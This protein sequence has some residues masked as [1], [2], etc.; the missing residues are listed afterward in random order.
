MK[1]ETQLIN[2]RDQMNLD[3]KLQ[4]E[5]NEA[6]KG[7]SSGSLV[8]VFGLLSM[9]LAIVWSKF[10]H[11]SANTLIVALTLCIFFVGASMTVYYQTKRQKLLKQLHT[12]PSSCHEPSVRT[13]T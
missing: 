4:D 6:R 9:L 3:R 2:R 1:K 7:S 12:L 10:F 11:E 8:S 13:P 5:I